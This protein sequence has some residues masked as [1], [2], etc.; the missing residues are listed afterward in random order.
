ME[1]ASAII[2][3][4]GGDE[5][6]GYFG[7]YDG[8]GGRNVAEFLRLHLHV[9]VEKE[10][11]SKGDRS[12]E[13]CLKAAFLVTDMACSATGEQASGSTAVVCI[14]RRQGPKRYVYTAN[15]GD[16][17][18]VLC[19][20]GNAVRLSKVRPALAAGGAP[21]KSRL[22]CP[23]PLLVLLLFSSSSFS[24]SFPPSPWQDHKATDIVERSR[25]EAAGGF[26]V[27]KRVMGVLA[28][29]RS[30]GDFVLKKF[31]SAEPYTSSTKL[32]V[33]VRR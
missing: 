15:C 12:V 24:S 23:F 13:E 1:D 22:K 26:V 28:V 18:A 11:R 33:T 3:G 2:D 30:F 19:H 8:H 14:V 10:L 7:I 6:T 16:A 29:A 31:V 20:D 5:A 25:I 17:R 27:R 4:F 9:N 32:D 21:K